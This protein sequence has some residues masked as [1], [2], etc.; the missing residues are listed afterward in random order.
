[1]K[2]TRRE[3]LVV[4]LLMQGMTAAQIAARLKRAEGTIWVHM[5]NI[6]LKTGCKN[7]A[8]LVMWGVRNRIA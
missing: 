4:R 8:M 1:M 3:L 5:R 6:H 2:L 7:R